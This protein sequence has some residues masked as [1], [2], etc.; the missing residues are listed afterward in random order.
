MALT[1]KQ[2][3][4]CQGIIDGLTQS[5]AYRRAYDAENMSNETVAVKASELMRDG[6]IS[7]RISELRARLEELQI[8]PRVQLLRIYAEIATR[9]VR[10]LNEKDRLKVAKD[11]DVIS[12]G[13]AYADL[14]GYNAP[15]KMAIEHSGTISPADKNLDDYYKDN[16]G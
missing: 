16:G 4:F 11:S 15:Q 1:H 9:N 5:D 12:A 6:N 3:T 8:L 2:E 7:V 10:K 14:V 13:K